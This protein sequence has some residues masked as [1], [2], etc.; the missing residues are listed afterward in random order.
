MTPI[1]SSTRLSRITQS[2]L[3]RS[4]QRTPG[5]VNALILKQS[6]TACPP[7]P[8]LTTTAQAM[9]LATKSVPPICVQPIE[10]LLASTDSGAPHRFDPG[11]EPGAPTETR[12]V[13]PGDRVCRG[14]VR[15]GRGVEACAG[16]CWC[17][18]CHS[19]R[20]L[21]SCKAQGCL[22]QDIA[23][24]SPRYTSTAN[25]ELPAAAASP[26]PIA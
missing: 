22:G 4:G 17:L 18:I 23:A 13:A 20:P 2:R 6:V 11:V 19:V 12:G 14:G 21:T 15:K 7:L 1:G 5:F 26:N 3:T 16:A 9:H 24:R 25:A 8:E 10:C